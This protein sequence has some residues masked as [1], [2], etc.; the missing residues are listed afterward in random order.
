MT[1]TKN[2]V[3]GKLV[4]TSPSMLST[5]DASTPFGCERRGYFKYVLGYEEPQ[6]ANQALGTQ[7]HAL[8]E[9]RLVSGK[10]P[11][12]SG[13]AAGLYLAGEK[14]IEEV[15]NRQILGVEL[16]VLNFSISG[17]PIKGFVDV[18][19]SDGI[20][21][22][23]TTS[24]ISK[25]GKTAESLKSDTQMLIYAAAMHDSLSVVKL[26]HGQFQTKAPYRAK[27]A[28]VEVTKK[29]IANHLDN[30]ITP[31][32]TRIKTVVGFKNANEATPDDT[33]CFRCPFRGP[34]K[35]QESESIMSIF[36][37]SAKTTPT[38]ETEM[39]QALRESVA[40]VLPPDAPKSDPA[41]AAQPPK[42]DGL[43]KLAKKKGRSKKESP[44]E[45]LFTAPVEAFAEA[46]VSDLTVKKQTALEE[47]AAIGQEMEVKVTSVTFSKGATINLGNFN[48]VRLDVSMTGEG[49]SYD[50]VFKKLKFE[51]E[52]RL[53]E[54]TAKLEAATK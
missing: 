42:N 52:E 16:P 24:D 50:I 33:K 43:E 7:L 13:P 12:A 51:V 54:E 36:Q 17:V 45:K 6:S 10:T 22:W 39:V 35:T 48:S 1:K 40:L 37:K 4:A 53:N 41:L 26:A 38:T 5:F 34:C 30:V 2:V 8:V 32:I 9:E 31:L 23:K 11:A 29:D 25:Y 15:A 19:T 14:M 20:V 18:V 28:E 46:A 27:L 49:E 3:D 21:D 47:L 44:Q